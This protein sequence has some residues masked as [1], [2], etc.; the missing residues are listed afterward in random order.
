MATLTAHEPELTPHE[1]IN[2]FERAAKEHDDAQTHFN[3]GTAYYV[4]HNLDAALAEFQ[5][6]VSLSPDLPHA[7]YYLGA[8]YKMRGDSESARKEFDQVLKG[9]G[10]FMIKN[11]ATIQLQGMNGR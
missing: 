7:H 2:Q 9:G 5:R 10:S 6:A 8:I 3:L 11:Q 1:A 4:A